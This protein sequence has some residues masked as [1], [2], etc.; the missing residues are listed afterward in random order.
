LKAPRAPA[1]AVVTAV[2]AV[3]IA[4]NTGAKF[5]MGGYLFV[6]GDGPH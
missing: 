1:I 2:M 5:F 3:P 6:A 4:R